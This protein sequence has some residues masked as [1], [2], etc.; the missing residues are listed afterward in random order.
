[1]TVL[2]KKLLIKLAAAEIVE[3]DFYLTLDA[4]II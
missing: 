4:D 2:K 1:M 3:T